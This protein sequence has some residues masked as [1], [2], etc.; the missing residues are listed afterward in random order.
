MGFVWH[1]ALR[2]FR[3]TRADAHIRVLSSL[4]AGGLAVGTAA[5][6]LALAAL[7]GFQNH[8]LRDLAQHTPTLQ[9]ELGGRVDS[10]TGGV[11]SAASIV[12]RVRATQGVSTAQELLYA[13]GWLVDRRGVVAVEVVGYEKAPPAWIPVE[14]AAAPGPNS[15]CIPPQIFDFSVGL[16]VTPAAPGLIVPLQVALRMGLTVGG[17]ARVASPRSSLTP[18]GPRPRVR[19]LP[20]AAIYDAERAGYEDLPVLLPL[21]QAAALFAGGDRRLDLTLV[22]AADPEEVAADLRAAIAPAEGSVA[23]WR[24]ANRALL[25]VLRLEKGLVFSAVALIVAVA[26][27]ALLASLSLVLSSKRSEV[28]VLAA[29]GVPPARLRGVFLSLGVLLSVG[30]AGVGVLIGAGVALFLDSFRV[31]SLPSDVYIVDYVPFLVREEDLFVVAF[32]TILF[33]GAASL[34]SARKA[35]RLD[36]VE[37][38]RSART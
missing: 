27:F 14:A 7:S 33:T 6:V 19:T 21:E 20:V 13:R 24:Q 2:Y 32:S 37:A 15:H 23:T 26:A 1:V 4:T 11:G 38:M 3:S 29:M 17:S 34:L 5:L 18:V 10:A 31:L 35:S 9:V 36:P 12:D 8:L 16:C 28:G 30:G 22:P 25:F